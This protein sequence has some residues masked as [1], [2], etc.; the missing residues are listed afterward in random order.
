MDVAQLT[1]LSRLLN[2]DP[3]V[4]VANQTRAQTKPVQARKERQRR[5][6]QGHS[7]ASVP[8]H[9][10]DYS[11]VRTCEDIDHLLMI[12]DILET[13]E[14]G[15][16]DL[17]KFTK[18]RIKTLRPEIDLY[19]LFYGKRKQQ[20]ISSMFCKVKQPRKQKS[21]SKMRMRKLFKCLMYCSCQ[22][23]DRHL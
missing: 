2:P 9:W 11:Y 12:W 3:A 13:E 1:S 15:F 22:C 8:T 4:S 18:E 16:P 10:L 23:C 5:R 14:T 21:V 6:A 19:T 7:A 17:L 20:E